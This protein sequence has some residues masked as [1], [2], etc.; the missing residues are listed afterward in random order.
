MTIVNRPDVFGQNSIVD[1][2]LAQG[3]INCTA[4]AFCKAFGESGFFVI[5]CHGFPPSDLIYKS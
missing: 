5:I 3:V 2:S 1:P 4:V